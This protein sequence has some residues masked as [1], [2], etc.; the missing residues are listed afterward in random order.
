[1]ESYGRIESGAIVPDQPLSLPEGARVQFALVS[2]DE[3]SPEGSNGE[4]AP[5]QGGQLAGRIEIADNFDILPD[6]IAEA[7]GMKPK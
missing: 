1:M 5:R 6:D 4:K 3:F 7:F 2:S